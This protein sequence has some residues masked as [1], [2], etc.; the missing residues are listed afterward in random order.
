MQTETP[1]RA[2]IRVK[3]AVIFGEYVSMAKYLAIYLMQCCVG[4]FRGCA[5][6]I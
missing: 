5:G 1:I 3:I 6:K 4:V 2:A